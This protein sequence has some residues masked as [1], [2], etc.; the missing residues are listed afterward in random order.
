MRPRRKLLLLLALAAPITALAQLG[1]GREVAGRLGLMQLVLVD[2]GRGGDR[3]LYEDAI[4]ILCQ[5]ATTCFVC[6]L[7]QPNVNIHVHMPVADETPV[8]LRL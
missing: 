7:H 1:N 5:P 8:E 6:F 3:V 4:A 2:A